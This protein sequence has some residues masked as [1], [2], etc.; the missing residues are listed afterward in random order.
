MK[1][2]LVASRYCGGCIELERDGQRFPVAA[3]DKRHLDLRDE[4]IS[5]YNATYGA[6][7]NPEVIPSMIEKLSEVANLDTGEQPCIASECAAT[8]AKAKGE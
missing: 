2:P 6:G 5:S 4:L 8:I 3:V 7:I 1:T